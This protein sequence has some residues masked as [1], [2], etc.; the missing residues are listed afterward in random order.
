VYGTAG[1]RPGYRSTWL[2]AAVAVVGA[3]STFVN[4]QRHLEWLR[5][6]IPAGGLVRVVVAA[7]DIE[8]GE[9]IGARMITTAGLPPIAVPKGAV[10]TPSAAV[11]STVALGVEEGQT[12]TGRTL[13]RGGPSALVP[14][15]MR[16]YDLAADFV[17][18][19][20]L[21]PRQGDRVDVIATFPGAS[22]E[23]AT[24]TTLLSG[25]TVAA[26]SAGPEGSASMGSDSGFGEL[27][28]PGSPGRITL[29]VTPEEAERLAVAESFG[30]IRV[31]V[32]SA[33]PDPRVD[34]S[35]ESGF[36][37]GA[38]AI[39]DPATE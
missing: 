28:G 11:G 14:P 5:S 19:A 9:I 7:R 32:A 27:A 10:R 37:P 25:R 33:H 29:L 36:P 2:W 20:P 16:A 30:R 39:G 22:A 31:V 35:P 3:V 34:H 15:G 12:I 13:G 23:E 38:P 18:G 8:A 17:P 26:F 1:V 6:Q 24:S 21:A 4:L